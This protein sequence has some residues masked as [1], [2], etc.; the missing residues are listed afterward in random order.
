MVGRFS[1]PGTDSLWRSGAGGAPKGGGSLAL[2]CELGLV[3]QVLG[4]PWGW[5]LD[6]G[7]FRTALGQLWAALLCA[8]GGLLGKPSAAPGGPLGGGWLL[9]LGTFWQVCPSFICPAGV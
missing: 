6:L 4:S 1:P 8:L 2:A 3:V 5:I 7:G 9:A